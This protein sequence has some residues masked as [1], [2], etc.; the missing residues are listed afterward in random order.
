MDAISWTLWPAEEGYN[1]DKVLLH[2]VLNSG[3]DVKSCLEHKYPKITFPSKKY[4]N[5]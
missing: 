4:H 5:S 1:R 2:G 3:S